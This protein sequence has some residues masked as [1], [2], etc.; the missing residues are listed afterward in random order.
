MCEKPLSQFSSKNLR[1]SSLAIYIHWPFCLSKCPYCNF[2]S[3]VAEKI[4]HQDW[5]QGLIQDLTRQH[6]DVPD[7]TVHTIFFGGGT[8]S[9]MQP[10]T[11]H[12]ILSTIRKLWATLPNAEV[13]LEANPT[14]VETANLQSYAQAGVNRLSIGVQSLDD[15]ILKRLGRTHSA[16][17]ALYA[18]ETAQEIFAE[19]VSFDLIYGCPEQTLS[20]WEKTL[21]CA[22]SIGTSHLS[23]YQL[24]IE[25]NTRY[26]DL[27]KIK[28]LILPCDDNILA[29]HQK[30]LELCSHSG[31]HQYEVSNYARSGYECQHN[32]TYWKYQD[33]LGCG[34]GA[35]GRLTIDSRKFITESY[36]DPNIWLDKA[37]R[38]ISTMEKH[39]Q[40]PSHEEGIEYLI[41]GIRLTEGISIPRYEA[42]SKQRFPIEILDQLQKQDMLTVTP[43]GQMILSKTGFLFSDHI[44]SSIYQLIEHHPQGCEE[45]SSSIKSPTSLQ[46]S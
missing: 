23:L 20:R 45:H 5:R 36:A 42:I 11:V 3:H 31:L 24:T 44:L 2:N 22:L 6:A 18:I 10:E 32:L 12:E 39:H 16:R 34:P 46:I 17:D 13:T 9:L 43:E 29:M 30:N 40:L 25:E 27:Y 7:K 26:H 33:Y 15:D 4:S 1:H 38:G 14:S 28:K 19:N 41:M 21:R 8:P 35:H 37:T